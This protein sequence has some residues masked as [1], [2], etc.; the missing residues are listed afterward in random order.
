MARRI[1]VPSELTPSRPLSVFNDDPVF[2]V[3]AAA[4]FLGVS[5]ELM[6][7]WRQRR[8]GPTYLQYQTVSGEPGPVLYTLSALRQFRGTHTVHPEGKK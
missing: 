6:K 3:G 4:T 2:K 1:V 7:K 8:Q 5:V